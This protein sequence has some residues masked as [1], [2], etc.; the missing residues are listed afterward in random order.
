MTVPELFNENNL[1]VDDL[2]KALRNVEARLHYKEPV[3]TRITSKEISVK[4]RAT[5]IRD[6]LKIKKKCDFTELF[7]FG[8]KDY[9]IA[10]FLAILEM[11]KTKELKLT[12]ENS[13]DS[14]IVEAI[15]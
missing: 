1:T 4:E 5:Y 8:T 11:C 6:I 3:E 2:V 14:I 15:A 13:F 9:I 10:T 12:Q 7:E